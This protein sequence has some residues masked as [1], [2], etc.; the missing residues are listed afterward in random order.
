MIQMDLTKIYRRFYPSTKDYN[1]FSA[2]H[3]KFFKTDDAQAHKASLNTYK[4][5]E[6]ATCTLTDY[7]KLKLDFN[8]RNSR[9]PTIS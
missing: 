6:I 1:Y 3:D 7:H 5:I 2:L 4:K 8:N 9:K